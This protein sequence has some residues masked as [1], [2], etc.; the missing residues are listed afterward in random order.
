MVDSYVGD[1]HEGCSYQHNSFIRKK[2]E[3]GATA[4]ETAALIT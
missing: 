3:I 4:W 2:N 1:L